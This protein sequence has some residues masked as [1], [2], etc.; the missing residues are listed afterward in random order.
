MSIADPSL[1]SFA[2]DL[3]RV[4]ET[5]D[6]ERLAEFLRGRH[7]P[8]LGVDLEPSDIISRAL[9][10]EPDLSWILAGLLAEVL[11]REAGALVPGTEI[12]LQKHLQ[13]LNGLQLAAELSPDSDLFYAL[14][15]FIEVPRELAF[16]LYNAL[17]YQQVDDSLASLWLERLAYG[18]RY[19]EEEL[20]LSWRGLLWVPS[21]SAPNLD[22]VEEGLLRLTDQAKGQ[23]R[24]SRLLRYALEILCET[25]PR[26][27]QYWESSFGPRVGH[28]P[29]E[30]QE[31]VFR[32]WP[33]LR[34]WEKRTRL[35]AG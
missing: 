6:A 8:A 21:H 31:E 14:C 10:E 9:A 23:P 34:D 16:A 4:V 7:L 22:L 25:Y 3:R 5:R 18:S 35:L 1:A 2:A 28:W 30:L 15:S 17:V 27:A 11:R 19:A 33:R 12:A 32:R 24:D 26:S 13:L 20:I 29:A